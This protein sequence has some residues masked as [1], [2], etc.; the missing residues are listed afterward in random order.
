M[1][2][3]RN[4]GHAADLFTYS[5]LPYGVDARIHDHNKRNRAESYNK[6]RDYLR[7]VLKKPIH[8]FP[9]LV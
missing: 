5:V 8:T 2:T 6:A 1:F 9:P 4:G 3:T 7:E